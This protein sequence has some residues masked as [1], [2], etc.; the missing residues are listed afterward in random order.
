[1]LWSSRRRHHF[2]TIIF[3]LADEA[4]CLNEALIPVNQIAEYH[5]PED[6]K[7][8]DLHTATLYTQYNNGCYT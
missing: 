8:H 5:G 3:F 2:G 4:V 7:M 6:I 1:M